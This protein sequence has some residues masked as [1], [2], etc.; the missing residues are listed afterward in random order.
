MPLFF[1]TKLVVT[2]NENVST[3]QYLVHDISVQKLVKDMDTPNPYSSWASGSLWV[4]VE[5]FDTIFHRKLES[6]EDTMEGIFLLNQLRNWCKKVKGI[7]PQIKRQNG[8]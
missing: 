3:Q 6:M 4:A 1:L 5:E 8:I 7:R 2:T